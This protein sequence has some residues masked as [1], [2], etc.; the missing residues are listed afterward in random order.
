MAA[1]APACHPTEPTNGGA[2]Q[3]PMRSARLKAASLAFEALGCFLSFFICIHKHSVLRNV[4]CFSAASVPPRRCD[5]TEQGRQNSGPIISQARSWHQRN[6][7]MP[8]M[9]EQKRGVLM[10]E[11]V[12]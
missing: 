9:K 10:C 3:G 5:V 7:V 2:K 6:L 4:T 8:P 11:H 12:K 1:C